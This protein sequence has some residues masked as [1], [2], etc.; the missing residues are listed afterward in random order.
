VLPIYLYI[1][2]ALRVKQFGHREELPDIG[3]NGHS[4]LVH[5]SF[6]KVMNKNITYSLRLV[7]ETT[8]YSA[9]FHH[10][11]HLCTALNSSLSPAHSS[12]T[13]TT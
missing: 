7:Y 10:H 3:E 5:N 11:K 6:Q 2:R 8:C 13:T 1:I 12:E 4:P 9:V